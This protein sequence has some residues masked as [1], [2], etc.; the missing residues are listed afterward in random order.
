MDRVNKNVYYDSSIKLRSFKIIL[1]RE[2][3]DKYRDKECSEICLPECIVILSS[4]ETEQLMKKYSNKA[5]Q[6]NDNSN[7][8]KKETESAR[9]L[10]GWLPTSS[11]MELP[12]L[13]KITIPE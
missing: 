3:F 4:T 11:D 8:R 9:L 6:C 1:K 13:K 7:K 10:V 5:K 2:N 12:V